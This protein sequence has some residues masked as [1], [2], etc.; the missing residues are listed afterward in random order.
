MGGRILF[1]DDDWDELE[2]LRKLTRHMRGAWDLSFACGSKDAI[3]H[4][5]TEAN[6]PDVIL[7]ELELDG[8]GGVDLLRAMQSQAPESIRLLCS[9]T[10]STEAIVRSVPWAHQ[11][12]PKPL[13]VADFERTIAY[14]QSDP[15][16]HE[17]HAVGKLA[18]SA[19]SLPVLPTT[20][21]RVMHIA[22]RPDFS[23]LEIAQVIQRDVALTA[24][25]MKVVN[26]SFFGLHTDVSSIEQAVSLLG[27]DVMRGLVL[28]NSLF[29]SNSAVSPWLDLA[30]VADRSQA[31]A[32]LAR[33]IAT[34]DGHNK[35]QQ[36]LAYLSGMVHSTGLLLL[37]RCP[38]IDLPQGTGIEYSID[39]EVDGRLF[40]IDRYALGAYLLRLWGFE[41]SIVEAVAGLGVR[42][43]V[44]Q[45]QTASTLRSASEL[46]AW[47]G[48]SVPAFVEGDPDTRNLVAAMR[49]EI[50]KLRATSTVS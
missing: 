27:L 40:G 2:E 19:D 5:A 22:N 46:I 15:T 36:A 32:A 42:F 10:K 3:R 9:A 25:T 31:V 45:G 13:D 39:P 18:A 34:V 43:D 6:P 41:R 12:L 44:L 7:T 17:S 24:A 35:H 20:Y 33:A 23:L 26:S 16:A 1:V 28:S 14:L 30:G 21:A 37:G 38:E 8:T 48:F 47:G 4:L 50:E 29:D 49:D 11:F